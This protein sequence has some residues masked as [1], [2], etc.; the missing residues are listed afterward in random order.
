MACYQWKVRVDELVAGQ[1]TWPEMHGN[2][3]AG[4]HHQD[5]TVTRGFGSARPRRASQDI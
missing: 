1:Q 2:G 3:L 4:Q 5:S